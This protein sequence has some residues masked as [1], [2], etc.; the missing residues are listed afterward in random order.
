MIGTFLFAPIMFLYAGMATLVTIDP[1][2]YDKTL[3]KAA[4]YLSWAS[5]I[6][7]VSRSYSFFVSSCYFGELKMSVFKCDYAFLDDNTSAQAHILGSPLLH[8]QSWPPS[9]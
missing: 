9:V 8:Y 5:I 6:C 7:S 2:L 4:I 1:M 3:E